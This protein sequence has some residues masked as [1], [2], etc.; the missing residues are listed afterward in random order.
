MLGI[1]DRVARRDALE[2]DRGGDVTR[3]DLADLLALVGVHLEETADALGAVALRAE[4]RGARLDMAGVDAEEDELADERVAHDL[5][6]QGRERR[7][8]VG[9]AGHLLLAVGLDALHGRNVERRR[10]VVE[11]RVEQRLYAL[12]LEGAAADDG[13]HPV[14]DR[15]APQGGL[16]LLVGDRFAREVLLEENVVRL[17][18]HLDHLLPH[19]VGG[20]EILLGDVDDLIVGAHRLVAIEDALHLHQVD[21]ALESLLAAPGKLN[22]H[23]VGGQAGAHHGHGAVEV[24]ADA[25]HLVDEREAGH[26]VVIGLAP[27]RLGLRLDAGHRVEAGHGAVEHAQRTLHLGREVHVAGRI[28]DVDAVLLPETGGGGGGD[29]DATLLLLH[30]PVHGGRALV[31]LTDLV[32]HPRV[33]EDALGGRR[34]TG[35]NVGHDAD[36]ARIVQRNLPSHGDFFAFVSETGIAK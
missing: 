4:H 22:H 27:H 9:R 8:V 13:L 15:R 2:A 28:D 18:D 32:V 17:R 26:A 20:V 23:G 3:P 31:H 12:V 21:D 19:L 6:H 10:Q 11:D 35:I 16:E 34:L 25:V 33:E 1:A 7:A 36:V 30:H 29:G 24:G 14:G 5:E